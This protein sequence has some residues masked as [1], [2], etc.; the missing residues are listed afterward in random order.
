[1]DVLAN[2][3]N[4]IKVGEAKSKSVVLL[5]PASKMLREVLLLLQKN[6]FVGE[7]EFIDD[8]KSG[9]FSV[10]L[11]GKIND[12]GVVKP[13]FPAK[14]SDLEKF[15][16]RF[17]PAAGIGLLIISTPKGLMTHNEAKEKRVGGRLIAFVY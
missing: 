17:L 2:A 15:E 1:M 13:R 16:Q 6:G 3:L 9:V 4:T 12:C 7:F 10:K 8:G 5:K 11:V 14:Y